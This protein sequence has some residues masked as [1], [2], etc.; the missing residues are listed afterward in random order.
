[1]WTIY[2]LHPA[3]DDDENFC[4]GIGCR[5]FSVKDKDWPWPTSMDIYF[6]DNKIALML[7]LKYADRSLTVVKENYE[8]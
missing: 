7:K 5:V 3:T 4:I 8:I 2:N 6:Q 1:M